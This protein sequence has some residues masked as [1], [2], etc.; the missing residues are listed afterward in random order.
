[1]GVR[2]SSIFDRIAL[3][4][5]FMFRSV[6]ALHFDVTDRRF[7]RQIFFRFGLSVLSIAHGFLLLIDCP[8]KR[9]RADPKHREPSKNGLGERFVFMFALEELLGEESVADPACSMRTII[10]IVS[11]HQ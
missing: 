4:S 10:E 5:L 9:M 11:C 3:F 6:A 8:V 2:R 7:T 1:M